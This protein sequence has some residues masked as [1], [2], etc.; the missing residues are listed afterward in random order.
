M[1]N[2]RDPKIA[3]YP[4][5]SNTTYG[6]PSSTEPPALTAVMMNDMTTFQTGVE[7]RRISKSLN[8]CCGDPQVNA[9]V[10]LQVRHLSGLCLCRENLCIN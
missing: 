10:T 4:T 6:S 2:L 8:I 7:E 1:L 5:E 3:R 9:Y